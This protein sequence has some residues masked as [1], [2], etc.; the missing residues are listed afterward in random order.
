MRVQPK[1]HPLLITR[2]TFERAVQISESESETERGGLVF[3][4]RA[5]SPLLCLL[6]GSRGVKRS[7]ADVRPQPEGELHR[8]D[9]L[10]VEGECSGRR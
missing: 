10:S 5:P 3:L 2:V 1:H 6:G 9:G 4:M 7:A 8:A